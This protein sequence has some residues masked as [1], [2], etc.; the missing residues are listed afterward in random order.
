MPILLRKVKETEAINAKCMLQLYKAL[1]TPQL[2]YAAA[3]WQI[4]NCAA[5]EN[6][7]LGVPG[8]ASLV[9]L[10]VEA[11]IKPIEIRR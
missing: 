11:G 6:L 3:V 2:E 4:S 8:T 5:L 7:V 10:E 9:A 1:V